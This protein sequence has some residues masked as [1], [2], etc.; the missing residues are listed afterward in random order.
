MA[1]K[2]GTIPWNKGLTKETSLLVEKNAES[3]KK[4]FENGQR[5]AWSK[6]LKG[7]AH[8]F[9]GRKLPKSTREKMSKVQSA[10]RHWN[11]QDG[12][13]D[14]IHRLRNTIKYQEWKLA[15]LERDNAICQHCG[16]EKKLHCH[17]LKKFREYPELRY[18]VNNGITLCNSC[19]TREHLKERYKV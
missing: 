19:H 11:W 13:T 5:Q 8:P 18:D 17:H 1:P 7:K 15:V 14:P 9:W 3:I 6:G 16:T 12:K 2:K 4:R 10:E